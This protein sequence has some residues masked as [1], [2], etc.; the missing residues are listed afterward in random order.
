MVLNASWLFFFFLFSK[1]FKSF[2]YRTVRN[3]LC[4]NK[5]ISKVLC[6]KQSEMACS[7]IKQFQKF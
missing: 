3:G 5:K 7:L 2:M 1:I 4:P 6:A